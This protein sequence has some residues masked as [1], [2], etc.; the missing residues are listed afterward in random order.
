MLQITFGGGEKKKPFHVTA[1]SGRKNIY[2][3]GSFVSAGHLRSCLIT[4]LSPFPQGPLQLAGTG[5]ALGT[6]LQ[7]D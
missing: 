7:M 3:P 4:V 2:T 5:G 6:T 1:E